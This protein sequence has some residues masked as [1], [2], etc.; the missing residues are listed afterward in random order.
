MRLEWRW[1]GPPLISQRKRHWCVTLKARPL[2]V[3]PHD[4]K[5]REGRRSGQTCST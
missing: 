1:V 5:E 4:A 3:A 2:S